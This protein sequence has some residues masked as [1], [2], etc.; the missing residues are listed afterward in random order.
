MLTAPAFNA[1]GIA[2][3]DPAEAKR[4]FQQAI[5]VDRLY[6]PAYNNLGV[7][8]LNEGNYYEAARAFDEAI[9]LM[10]GDPAPRLHLGVVYEDAGQFNVPRWS[11]LIRHWNWHPARWNA[12]RRLPAFK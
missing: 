8:Y 4:L 10:P 2:A 3:K 12:S 7:V 9:K 6:G 11:S 5:A 1:K